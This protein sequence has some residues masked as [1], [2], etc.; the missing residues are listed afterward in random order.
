MNLQGIGRL[1]IRKLML[2]SVMAGAIMSVGGVLQ[3][4]AQDADP[5]YEPPAPSF[6][7]PRLSGEESATHNTEVPSYKFAQHLLAS[8]AKVSKLEQGV[9]AVNVKGDEF[10]SAILSLW[11]DFE[12]F[13]KCGGGTAIFC[14][15]NVFDYEAGTIQPHLVPFEL[16]VKRAT[17]ESLVAADPTGTR[18]GGT[19]STVSIT[20]LPGGAEAT[21]RSK[22]PSSQLAQYLVLTA[23]NLSTLEPGVLAAQVEGGNFPNTIFASGE[24]FEAVGICV[25]RM[26][27]T[28]CA[29]S[30][31]DYEDEVIKRY[32]VPLELAVKRSTYEG[33]LTR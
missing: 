16:A 17:Y 2:A 13:G 25:K 29:M 15:M 22:A 1:R 27:G 18:T 7:I 30:V 9:L 10:P 8:G 19:G 24:D 23:A 3:S 32:Y 5:Q 33:L 31:F 14:E 28:G 20:P 26:M 6:S 21:G 4:L 12:A 11:D